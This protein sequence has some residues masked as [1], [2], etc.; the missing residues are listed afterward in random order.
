MS[1]LERKVSRLIRANARTQVSQ[2]VANLLELFEHNDTRSS[3]TDLGNETK[4]VMREN[5]V[6]QQPLL[7]TSLP[8]GSF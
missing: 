5:D 6:E 4:R 2:C 8:G 7:P 1:E 3:A